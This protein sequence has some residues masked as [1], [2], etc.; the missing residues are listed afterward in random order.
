MRLKTASSWRVGAAR[1]R[2]RERKKDR[3]AGLLL[4]LCGSGVCEVGEESKMGLAKEGER[5][6]PAAAFF[7]FLAQ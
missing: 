1:Q 3:G 7:Y 4:G 5:G 6:W 2:D